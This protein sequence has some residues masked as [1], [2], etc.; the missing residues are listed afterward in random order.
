MSSKFSS[1]C[2]TGLVVKD[3]N[4]STANIRNGNFCKVRAGCAVVDNL[5][6]E[7]INIGNY[8]FVLTMGTSAI[9]ETPEYIGLT[10]SPG[11]LPNARWISF[12]RPIKSLHTN[13]L[14]EFSSGSGDIGFLSIQMADRTTGDPLPGVDNPAFI[15]NASTMQVN[16]AVATHILSTPHPA[17]TSFVVRFLQT[18]SGDSSVH[19]YIIAETC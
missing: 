12:P 13:L 1:C 6:V 19:C 14:A 17:N 8:I 4:F 16:G 10:F 15:G 2:Q 7:S 11:N 9:F 18:G 3:A 5:Q